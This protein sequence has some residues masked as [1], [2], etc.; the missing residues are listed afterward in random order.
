MFRSR[1]L[2]FHKYH[3]GWL[4]E[5]RDCSRRRGRA[6]SSSC[7][8]A[9][10]PRCCCLLIITANV[11]ATSRFVIDWFPPLSCW[12]LEKKRRQSAS[13]AMQKRDLMVNIM[14]SVLFIYLFFII[15]NINTGQ[16]FFIHCFKHYKWSWIDSEKQK[17]NRVVWYSS[18]SFSFYHSNNTNY[19]P[20][21]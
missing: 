1:C 15:G 20:R 16:I 2:H 8:S 3:S 17:E 21:M 13:S 12:Q 9:T 10:P 7:L 6:Q 14:V 19:C 4:I 18:G 5:L 11:S